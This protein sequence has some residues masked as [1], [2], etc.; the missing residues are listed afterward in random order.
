MKGKKIL[1][2]IGGGISAYKNVEL[3]RLLKK[4]NASVNVVISEA[5]K[6]FIGE[7]TLRVLSGNTVFSDMFDPKTGADVKHIS[8]P[9]ESDIVVVAPATADIIG[10]L[11]SGIANDL[12]STLLLVP[13]PSKVLLCP[14]MNTGMWKN[15]AVQRNIRSLEKD[16]YNVLHP[17][18]GE[19]AC[20]YTGEGR[21]REP[22]EILSEI[23]KILAPN[24]L[25]GLRIL[26]TAG[27]TRERIDDIRYISNPSSGKMGYAFAEVA[28]TRGAKVCLVSGPV[29]IPPPDD[30]ELINVENADEMLKELKKRVKDYHILIKTAAVCDFKPVKRIK[31]KLKKEKFKKHIPITLTPDILEELRKLNNEC[32]FIGFSAEVENLVE[33]AMEKLKKKGLDFIVINDVSRKEIGFG[34]D[35]NEG[36]II[37][38]KGKQIPIPFLEKHEFAWRVLDVVKSS[39]KF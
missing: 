10:K 22:N 5:G 35:Y 7:T 15:P 29:S 18:S 24:D 38:S 23:R 8:L 11:A 9:D 27:P 13:P 20:G 21:M 25:K 34:S 31:G 4:E 17:S 1:L 26:I 14:A 19:L 39:V 2:C 28:K 32:V 30:V 6:K 37:S 3:I 36:C 12:L 33:N 16:G